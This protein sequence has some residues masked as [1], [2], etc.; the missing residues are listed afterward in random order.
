M[1]LIDAHDIE[2]EH[3][4]GEFRVSEEKINAMPTVCDIED[5]KTEI[6]DARLNQINDETE[7]AVNYGLNTALEIID[8]HIGTEMKGEESEFRRQMRLSRGESCYLD[9]G[10]TQC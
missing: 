9:Q 1:K 5:I 2:Y 8:K 4:C 6:K 3:I 10:I 7:K